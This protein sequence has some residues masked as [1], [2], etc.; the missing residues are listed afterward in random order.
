MNNKQRKL[1][2]IRAKNAL[3][4]RK[5]H[6]LR[7]D[8]AEVMTN[9]QSF[10]LNEFVNKQLNRYTLMRNKIFNVNYEYNLIDF[11]CGYLGYG[12]E[13]GLK[14]IRIKYKRK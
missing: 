7:F 5:I 12:F 1:E 11:T 13:K 8:V 14:T 3:R 2:Y 4:L 10:V 6:F 9:Q